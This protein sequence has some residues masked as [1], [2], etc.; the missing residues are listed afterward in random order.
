M[1]KQVKGTLMMLAAAMCWG[2]SFVAGSAGMEFVGPFTF[3]T[4]RFLIGFLL[5]VAVIL[6]RTRLRPD[7][8]LIPRTQ[9][10]KQKLLRSGL[11]CGVL[12]FA[13]SILQQYGLAQ[14][15]FTAGKCGFITQLY[16]PL[17]PLFGIF[18]GRKVHPLIFVSIVIAVAGLYLLCID[19]S[20]DGPL[21]LGM[22][23][24]FTILCAV[25]Y[26]LHILSVDR[27]VEGQDSL[28]FVASQFAVCI[29]L[30]AAC[31]VIFEKPDM[32]AILR[33]RLPILYSGVFACCV[34]YTLQAIAIKFLD[35]TLIAITSCTESVFS[36]VF[37]WLI[38]GEVIPPRG[39]LG[40]ALML[41]GVLLAQ[42]LT[43][44]ARKA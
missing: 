28:R 21:T 11:I 30:S 41:C 27:F 29:V 22:G 33:C 4:V 15:G 5:L 25:V 24:I 20:V 39:L 38:L 1:G 26:A 14:P 40:C 7:D 35:A 44:K 36:A 42:L 43:A 3:Q 37:G 31:M 2:L 9:E 32:Q 16:V 12:L 6:V 10:Q 23:E 34:A 18:L 19:A 13:G 8:P 17:V